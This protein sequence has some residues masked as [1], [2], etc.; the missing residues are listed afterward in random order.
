MWTEFK[1]EYRATKSSS[2]ASAL[3]PL[4]GLLDAYPSGGS[5]EALAAIRAEIRRVCGMTRWFTQNPAKKYLTALESLKS[6]LDAEAHR[7]RFKDTGEDAAKNAT[8]NQAHRR[9]AYEQML[10]S[11]KTDAEYCAPI[12]AAFK[13]VCAEEGFG[14]YLLDEIGWTN[15][16]S[17]LNWA[18]RAVTPSMA[19]GWA[20]RDATALMR[21][22]ALH[23][24]VSGHRYL[25][26]YFLEL[27][28]YCAAA[29]E[30]ADIAFVFDQASLVFG[31]LIGP[32][33]GVPASGIASW[34]FS[35]GKKVGEIAAKG[36]TQALLVSASETTVT[37][38]QGGKPVTEQVN[39]MRFTHA[40][41]KYATRERPSD[42]MKIV[43]QEFGG[44]RGCERLLD[45]LAEL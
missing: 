6:E 9:Y 38:T 14:R 31:P 33:L 37:S 12:T 36:G 19:A 15:A 45:A 21:T 1:R 43:L 40:W 26:R 10:K 8:K 42:D 32:A 28:I 41:L 13:R 11:T 20:A 16:T 22:M 30:K 39:L 23:A 7:L 27:S 25:E 17:W 18:I 34:G 2:S 29:A 35:A 44:R 24:S 5:E 3:D 4:I